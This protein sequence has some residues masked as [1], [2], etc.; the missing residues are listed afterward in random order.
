MLALRVRAQRLLQLAPAAEQPG[1]DG[2][3]RDAQL[4]CDLLVRVTAQ[5]AHL[6]HA[7]EVGGQV[8][9]RAGD[10]VGQRVADTRHGICLDRL[11]VDV[12]CDLDGHVLGLHASALAPRVV[13]VDVRVGGDSV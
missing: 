5:V 3:D 6:D 8:C 13:E 11:S 4:L 2:A 10:L 7:A 1:H 12:R 9:Q